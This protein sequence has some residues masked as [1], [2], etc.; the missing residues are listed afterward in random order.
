MRREVLRDYTCILRN[1]LLKWGP[2]AEIDRVKDGFLSIF[3]RY[4]EFLTRRL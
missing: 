1:Y 2:T 4:Q 3:F